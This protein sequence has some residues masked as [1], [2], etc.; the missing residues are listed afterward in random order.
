MST[1]GYSEDSQGESEGSQEPLM[2][3]AMTSEPERT[4]APSSAVDGLTITEAAAAYGISVS[5]LRRRLKAGEIVGAAKVTGP[6]GQEY[7][8]PPE[9]LE[10]LCMLGGVGGGGGGKPETAGK[11]HERGGQRLKL[12]TMYGAG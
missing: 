6:K 12:R 3:E 4:Q 2:I 7:R 9:A 8:V 10:A 5:T 11:F 1:T